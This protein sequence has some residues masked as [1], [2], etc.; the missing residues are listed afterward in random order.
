MYDVVSLQNQ[1]WPQPA[2]RPEQTLVIGWGTH[3]N[4]P[5]SPGLPTQGQ[6]G[7]DS[8]SYVPDEQIEASHTPQVPDRLPE[9]NRAQYIPDGAQEGRCP[10]PL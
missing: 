7:E 10:E 1:H 9:D 4:L 5:H 6:A 3:D 8:I 2:L